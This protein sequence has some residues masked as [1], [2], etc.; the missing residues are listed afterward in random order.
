LLYA[1]IS[2]RI[3]RKRKGKLI[4]EDT[5]P[6]RRDHATAKNLS[7]CDRESDGCVDRPMQPFIRKAERTRWSFGEICEAGRHA[8][9][10]QQQG[11]DRKAV[12]NAL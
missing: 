7:A 4:K 10:I 3:G 8:A 1:A 11:S 5:R 9:H 12:E 2:F 6:S